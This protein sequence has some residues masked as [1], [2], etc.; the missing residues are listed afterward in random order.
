MNMK[1][2]LVIPFYNESEVVAVFRESILKILNQIKDAD[3]EIICVDDGSS[4]DT[5]LQLISILFSI[6]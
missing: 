4:D 6:I 3:F 1:I 5:L 2:S